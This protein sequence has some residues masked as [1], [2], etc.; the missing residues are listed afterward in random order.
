MKIKFKQ[1]EQFEKRESHF[2][3]YKEKRRS[4]TSI[5]GQGKF[6]SIVLERSNC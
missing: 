6:K 3:I 1:F 4:Y 5:L 2:I